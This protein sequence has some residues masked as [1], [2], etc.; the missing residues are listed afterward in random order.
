M[1]LAVP[2]GIVPAKRNYFPTDYELI[3]GLFRSFF[4]KDWLILF[5][6][7]ETVKQ[8][9]GDLV[10]VETNVHFCLLVSL[11]ELLCFIKIYA[12]MSE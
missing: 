8:F 11:Y 6:V 5:G 7:T 10:K 1:F 2:T 4:F 12:R 9:M 3:L